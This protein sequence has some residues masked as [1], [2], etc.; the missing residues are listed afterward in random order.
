MVSCPFFCLVTLVMSAMM[1][2]EMN[3]KTWMKRR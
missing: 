3:E 2:L 1:L